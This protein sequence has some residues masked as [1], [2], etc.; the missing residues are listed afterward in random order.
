MNMFGEQVDVENCDFL[1]NEASEL[2]G[3]ILNINHIGVENSQVILMNLLFQDNVGIG[4]TLKLKSLTCIYSM[5]SDIQFIN[6]Y[7][8][9]SATGQFYFEEI[10]Y[11]NIENMS[12][13]DN[14]GGCKYNLLI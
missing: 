10:N 3:G 1:E 4:G 7:G 2:N 12:F 6:N 5:L 9:N 14:Y 13:T 8:N 11:L